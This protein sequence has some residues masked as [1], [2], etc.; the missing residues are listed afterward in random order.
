[1]SVNA[2]QQRCHFPTTVRVQPAGD[3]FVNDDAG[4]ER[5]LHRAGG[6]FAVLHEGGR[7]GWNGEVPV[8]GEEESELDV[9][10]KVEQGHLAERL[11]PV[12]R[13]AGSLLVQ[14]LGER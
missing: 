1:M 13:A 5:G 4:V 2:V 7:T 11:L 6:D 14:A 8:V 9:L 3:E 10:R 12:L